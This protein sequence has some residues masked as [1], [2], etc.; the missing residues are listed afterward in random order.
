MKWVD[1]EKITDIITLLMLQIV[2]LIQQTFDQQMTKNM[3][4]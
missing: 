2:W 3:A 1:D 4:R